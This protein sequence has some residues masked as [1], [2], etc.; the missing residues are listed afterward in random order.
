MGDAD[1]DPDWYGYCLDDPVN[2]VDPLGLW[3]NEHGEEIPKGRTIVES[4]ADPL[5]SPFMS[6][7]TKL[8]VQRGLRIKKDDYTDENDWAMRKELENEAKGYSGTKAFFDSYLTNTD[9]EIVEKRAAKAKL[10]I[11]R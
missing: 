11:G 9:E 1:G 4:F 6:H 7:H 2:G 3:T 10:R 5:I 8:K